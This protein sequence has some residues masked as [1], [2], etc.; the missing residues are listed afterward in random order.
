MKHDKITDDHVFAGMLMAA[1][2]PAEAEKW[3]QRFGGPDGLGIL[4]AGRDESLSR[5]PVSEFLR[6]PEAGADGDPI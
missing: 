1:I 2:K 3:A 4:Q 5:H 6:E